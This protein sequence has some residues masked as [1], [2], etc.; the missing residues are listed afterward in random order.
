[1]KK[2]EITLEEYR[3]LLEAQA[4]LYL[5]EAGGV[6][7]WTWYEESLDG[8]EEEMERIDELISSLEE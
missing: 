2:I 3:E 8:L 7:N 4:T 6:D 1:M 5:L